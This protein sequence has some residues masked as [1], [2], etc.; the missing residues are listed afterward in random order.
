MRD[1]D[2]DVLLCRALKRGGA[3]HARLVEQVT[4]QW[5]KKEEE[6]MNKAARISIKTI[7]VAAVLIAIL[8]GSALAALSLLKPGEVAKSAGDSALSAAFESKDALVID[9][10]QTSGNYALMLMGLVSGKDISDLPFTG[11]GVLPERS[12][13]VVAIRRADGGSV[14]A[15]D[16]AALYVSP[17]VKGLK[18][19]MVNINTMN[20]AY[21]EIMKDGVVYRIVECDDVAM[22]ADKGL[23][24]C[25]SDTVTFS[26]EAF[27]Y[28]D[29]TGDISPRA[30]FKGVN[31]L[32][33]LP[34]DP[35]EAD[36]TKAAEYLKRIGY[37]D[38]PSVAESAIT[39][40]PSGT[41]PELT[42]TKDK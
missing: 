7:T 21:S 1:S 18:P 29:E 11:E 13:A 17:L 34:I 19:W 38:T 4:Y 42:I 25:I 33:N 41:A 16:T 2:L 26:K 40:A 8:A 35:S 32:F 36:P 9:D 22:F 24:L 27:D 12:Y 14:T 20:G 3:P 10:T 15:E 30:D 6:E 39:P 31:A 28:S 37:D 23:Y 5:V